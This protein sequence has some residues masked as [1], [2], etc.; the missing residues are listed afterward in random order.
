[1]TDETRPIIYRTGIGTGR[2]GRALM[3]AVETVRRCSF[4]VQ[5][6]WVIYGSSGM[7][8]KWC[9]CP[10]QIKIFVLQIRI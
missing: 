1:M 3:S 6:K 2:V 5:E 10:I 7:T 9:L 4:P 8:I